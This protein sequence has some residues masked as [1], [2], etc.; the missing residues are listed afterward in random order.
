METF[1]LRIKVEINPIVA[2]NNEGIEKIKMEALES[3]NPNENLIP[4][5]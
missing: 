1:L 5:F 2:M 4:A 3:V